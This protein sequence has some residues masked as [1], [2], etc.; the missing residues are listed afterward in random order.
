MDSEPYYLAS[1]KSWYIKTIGD[2]GKRSQKKIGNTKRE[3]KA[4]LDAIRR[5]QERA[6]TANGLLLLELVEQWATLQLTRVERGEVTES[7]LGRRMSMLTRFLSDNPDLSCDDLKPF[8]L[9]DW[10]A[11]QGWKPNTERMLL[12]VAKQVL[13]WGVRTK[14]IHDS[15]IE[16]IDMPSTTRSEGIVTDEQHRQIIEKC[17]TDRRTRPLRPLLILLRNS[18][19]RPGELQQLTASQLSTDCSTIT[20]TKHKSSKKTGAKTIYLSPCGQTIARILCSVRSDVLLLNGKGQPWTRNAVRIRF[21]RLRESL[22]LPGDIVAYSY[23]HAYATRAL[24]AG[25][26]I[27]TVAELLGHA[28]TEMISRH[29][30]HLA[31]EK[32]HLKDAAARVSQQRA[33][34]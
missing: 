19:C 15:P 28:S 8:I 7:W 23:R 12:T 31:Q 17:G 20:L 24:V 26:D 9:L 34:G 30:G 27:A 16:S 18:G 13:R 32:N 2:N 5:E 14:R 25:V 10:I 33:G 4:Y 21:R 29:Y 6:E 3:A 1:R 11:K 22:G